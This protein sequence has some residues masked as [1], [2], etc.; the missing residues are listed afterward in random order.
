MP[1][2]EIDFLLSYLNTIG[3]RTDSTDR[4]EAGDSIR[5]GYVYDLSDVKRAAAITADSFPIPAALDNAAPYVWS[6][7]GVFQP[8]GS[9]GRMLVR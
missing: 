5:V 7:Y 8:G 2:Q 6:C 3:R 4:P 1:D 9:S